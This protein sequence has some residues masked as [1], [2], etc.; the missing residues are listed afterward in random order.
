MKSISY[1]G[2]RLMTGDDIA[3]AVLEYSAALSDAATAATVEIPVLTE[4]GGRSHAILLVGPASQIVAED[5]RTN[6]A[7]LVDAATVDLLHQK[8]SEHRPVASEASAQMP[9]FDE[10][11]PWIDDY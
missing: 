4:Q 3:Q 1:A 2:S 5:V 9:T 10:A 11:G 8:T 6:F 7:E